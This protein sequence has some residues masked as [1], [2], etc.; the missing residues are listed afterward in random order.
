MEIEI[1]YDTALSD[2]KEIEKR[3]EKIN[4]IVVDI[5]TNYYIEKSNN[6][7]NIK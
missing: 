3:I 4:K 1:I 7:N 5:A 6:G 2:P